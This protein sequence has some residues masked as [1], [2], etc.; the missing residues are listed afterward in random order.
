MKKNSGEGILKLFAQNLEAFYPDLKNHYMCPTCLA[1]ISL[2][3]KGRIS[4]AHII[5]KYAGGNLKTYL[6]RDCNSRFGSK[7][8]KWF[9]EILRIAN[10]KKP[11]IFSTNI[12]DGY[13]MID[14]IRINGH[15]E[16]DENDNFEFYIHMDRNSPQVNKKVRERLGITRNDLKLS[17]PLPILR[18]QRF[19]DI[20][21]LTAGYLMGFRA[22]GYSW[23]LQE[24][25][26]PIRDQILNSDREIIT[27]KYL[28]SAHSVNW[29][30]WFGIMLLDCDYVPVF[31][32]G[33][34]LVAFP[35]RDR[36]NLYQT[37]GTSSRDIPISNLKPIS[38]SRETFYVFPIILMFG[39]RILV[40][41][42]QLPKLMESLV[43]HFSEGSPR[44]SILRPINKDEFERL[45]KERE[46][47]VISAKVEI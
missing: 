8:D 36:P 43:I 41:S 16:K 2:E 23:V 12:K 29:K 37:L 38:F 11:S 5:P 14:D 9:G 35:P 31:A 22:L 27:A 47:V 7:Q 13:F 6:C 4:E 21:F 33:R 45:K 15:W 44:A 18:N 26:Q 46:A 24:H 40:A 39:N 28:F 34:H 20:G 1:K 17:F 25:L 42:D 19:V 3:E 30:P 32:V 10:T